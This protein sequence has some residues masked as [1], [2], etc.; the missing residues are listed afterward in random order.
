MP[1]EPEGLA[2][3]RDGFASEDQVE[4]QLALWIAWSG[5]AGVTQTAP[6]IEPLLDDEEEETRVTAA[7]VLK[8]MDRETERSKAILAAVLADADHPMHA[9]AGAFEQSIGA[10]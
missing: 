1:I 8:K 4:R 5:G 10:E 9:V 7:I 2:I 6:W 3:A